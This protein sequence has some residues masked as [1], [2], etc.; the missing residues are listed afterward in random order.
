MEEKKSKVNVRKHVLMIPYP[1]QG[2]INPMLNF[3]K[4]LSTK[5]V[6]VTI[7][8]TI[9][10]SKSMHRL[11]SSSLPDSIQ[12]DT[13]SDGYDQG[14]FAQ[15]DSIASYLSNMELV[16]SK[17]LRELI[18]KYNFSD[19][20]ISGLVYDPFLP[21][22]LEVGKEF[23]LVGAAF[24]TQMCAVNYIYYH[25]HHGLLNLPVSSIPI[26]IQGLPLLEL[27]DTPSFVNNPGFYP[28]YFHMVMNQ[29]S[30]IYKADFI[31]VNSFYKLEEQVVDSMSKL[32]PLLTIG[33]TVP[34]FHLDKL[35]P[36]D[37]DND[38]HLHS[39]DS[40]ATTWLN[41]K[42]PG[43][44]IYVSFGS[45]VCLS[46]EQM[47][48]LALGLKGTGFNFIW[49]ITVLE[50]KKLS[51]ELLDEICEDEKGLVVNWIP[52]LEVLSNKA[53]GCFLTHC[54]WNSTIE[55]LSLGVPMVAM[56]QWTDQPMD[57]KFVEDVWKVG[58]RV[59]VNENNI[60]KSEEIEFC[61]RQ[62]MEKDSGKQFRINA[63]KWRDLAIEAV[64]EGGTSDNN[65][66]EFVKNLMR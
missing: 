17:N 11:Q 3:S 56:P 25:V 44:V 60:V 31:L 13:I 2:H 47:E 64:S 59:K 48:E 39:L 16:G 62:V 45:M 21:W 32:L 35:S 51:K 27:K 36:N 14:G 5:G 34:S 58:I 53:I 6:C 24:F 9:F 66:N 49:V 54:G 61:V 41:S 63:K 18:Q 19:Y 65:I 7:V 30:N 23:G 28:P 29:F 42:P 20:P 50:R 10:I 55:A 43:S 40:S 37:T 52:Q 1:S 38:I 26:S 22:A 12:F 57:A 15:A 4:R 8:T 33:P 46:K